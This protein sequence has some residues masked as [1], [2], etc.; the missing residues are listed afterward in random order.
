M[1][2]PSKLILAPNG[3][4]LNADHIVAVSPIFESPDM[5]CDAFAVYT[6][7]DGAEPFLFIARSSAP[8]KDH[9]KEF[10]LAWTAATSPCDFSGS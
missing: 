4:L 5:G 3:T 1:K 10:V 2:T 7:S 8:K 6:V 9:H